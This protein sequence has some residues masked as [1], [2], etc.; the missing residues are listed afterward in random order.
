MVIALAC[1]RGACCR[2]GSVDV[3]CVC[4]CESRC[5]SVNVRCVCRCES[6]CGSVDVRCAD[7]WVQNMSV[8]RHVLSIGLLVSIPGLNRQISGQI[9]TNMGVFQ[10]YYVTFAPIKVCVLRAVLVTD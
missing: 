3:R 10:R 4:Q 7:E 5:G 6:R 8:W 2:C 1:A 9:K